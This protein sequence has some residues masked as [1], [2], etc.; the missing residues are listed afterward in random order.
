MTADL[1]FRVALAGAH[2]LGPRGVEKLESTFGD[3]GLAWKAS[4][5]EL[6]AAGLDDR[7]IK[8]ISE[9]RA[10]TD[11]NR[12]M[13][14][15]EKIGAWALSWRDPSYPASLRNIPA[16]PPILFGFGN[17][18]PADELGVAIVGTR[19]MTTYGERATGDIVS[20]LVSAGVTVVS[21]LA[22]GVDGAAHRAALAAGGRTIAVLGGAL[23]ELYPRQHT[24]LAKRIAESGAVLTEYP[25]G[26]KPT[27]TNFP[28][29]NRVV[30][31]LSRGVL[32]VEAGDRSGATITAGYALDQGKEVFAIPGPVYAPQSVGTNRLI[33]VGAAK[34]VTSAAD[35]LE[36]LNLPLMGQLSLTS[37]VPT[38]P[39][40]AEVVRLLRNGPQHIDDISNDLNLP[41]AEVSVALAMLELR[42]DIRQVGGMTYSLS[43]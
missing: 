33:Q 13:S 15:I 37:E 3:L 29:R 31:G 23:D 1:S 6:K 11:P 8:S 26:T 2:W 40:E 9:L 12:E 24:S 28:Q 34:L 4:A 10:S 25:L 27:R 36:E 16:A 20:D 17:L 35:I 43:R 14:K 21:G 22:L 41:V 18:T 39:T 5:A 42:G 30:S 19:N 38:D 7:A 32:V